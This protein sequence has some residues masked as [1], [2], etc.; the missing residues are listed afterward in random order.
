MRLL[1]SYKTLN[2]LVEQ[3]TFEPV[4]SWGL[5]MGIAAILPI[6]WGIYT[7][8]SEDAT[9]ITLTAES[10]CWV[11]LKGSFGQRLRILMGGIMLTLFFGMLGSVTGTSLLLSLLCMVLVGF[12]SGLFKNLGDRG[13]GLAM[14]VFVLFIITNNYPTHSW[15][16]LQHRMELILA[17]GLWNAVV[18]IAAALYTPA[19]QP[20]RRTIAVIWKGIH[21]LVDTVAKGWDGN[22]IR[23]NIRDIYLKEKDVRAAIDTSLNLYEAMAHQANKKDTHEYE[24]AQVR[25]ATA[26][27][28]THIIAMSEELEQISI[29]D[30]DTSLRLKIYAVLKA[31]QQTVDRMAVYVVN[32]KPEEELLLESRITRME[33]LIALLKEYYIDENDPNYQPIRRAT[34]LAERCTKLIQSSMERLEKSRG[35]RAVFRSYS[36]IK[37]IFILHPKHWIRNLQVLFNFNTFTTRYAIRAAVAATIGLFISKWFNI[38]HGYWLPFTTLLV[39]QPYFGATIKKAMDRVVGTVAGGIA[40]GLIMGLPTGLYIKEIVLFISFVMMVYFINKRYA[41][42]VFFITLSLVMIFNVEGSLDTTLLLTRGLSTIGGATL[43]II[44]GFALLPH[45]DTK[46]LPLHLSD[47]INANYQY[48]RESF[49]ADARLANWTRMKRTA[50]SKNT[51]A[52]DSFNRYMQEPSLKRKTVSLYYHII[53]HN[54]RI[55][56][57]LNNIHLEEDNRNINHE[58]PVD[59]EQKMKLHTALV[60]FNK[61]VRLSN[62]INLDKQVEVMGDDVQATYNAPLSETQLMYLDRMIIELKAMHTDLLHLAN[63]EKE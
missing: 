26:L 33:K 10:I 11:E 3:E 29:R 47:C 4:F 24:L 60:W 21:G 59:I 46:W 30:I 22:G 43:A 41:V 2:K 27:V 61:N 17:G 48:F 53:T 1:P 25:K 6:L 38:S 19:K 44:A 28:A 57:E 18:G 36:L 9:W 34:Q 56:R 58:T 37:T 54:V 5:R 35:E 62:A 20:Y 23:S 12:M 63:R 42:A 39:L 13:S 49:F 16:E 52:F 14:S 55:T 32:L 40:G 50:E 31:L 7:G 45:W 51:N 15:P 8:R